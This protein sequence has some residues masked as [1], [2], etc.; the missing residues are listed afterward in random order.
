VR[1]GPAALACLLVAAGG[2]AA[3]V[4]VGLR[5]GESR[6]VEAPAGDAVALRT[7]VTPQR[8]FMG[9]RVTGQ[10]ELVVDTARVDPD[11]VEVAAF[12][13]PFRRVGPVELERTDL[14]A[15]TVLRYRYPL[16]CIDRA[17]APRASQKPFVLPLGVVRYSPREGDVVTLPLSWPDVTVVT[18]LDSPGL[19][20]ALD[21][22]ETV[23]ADPAFDAV[24]PLG[25]RGGSSLLGWLLIGA[26]CALVA[27]AGIALAVRLR[28]RPEQQAAVA[29]EGSALDPVDAAL[30]H[31]RT[32]ADADGTRL[33]LDG[34][35][36][37]LAVEGEERL[38]ADAR[39]LAWSQ[40]GPVAER[41][42]TLVGAVARRRA[43]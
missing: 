40:A 35:A 10:L 37:A 26:A 25:L 12:F 17:C 39:R 4:L 23:V 31:L 42:D 8:A 36:R 22:P 14:D 43:A 15:S 34:L 18:R 7:S 13:R 6:S 29:D 20:A 33:A 28:P 24:P 19:A 5:G 32:A 3:L 41:I 38:A 30:A 11:S 27:A 1:R 16:Q 21:R 2:I 9:D